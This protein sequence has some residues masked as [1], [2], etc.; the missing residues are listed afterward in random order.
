MNNGDFCFLGT[1]VKNYSF[2]K[3]IL[4]ANVR[5][6]LV[7]YLCSTPKS[8]K[9]KKFLLAIILL[10]SVS[11]SLSSC[12]QSRKLGCPAVASAQSKPKP[13]HS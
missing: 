3:V 2:L 5:L 12:Y 10:A 4:S 11:A 7:Y 1:I 8:E 9:M 6:P 13:A